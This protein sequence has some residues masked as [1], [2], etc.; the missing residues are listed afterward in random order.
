[1]Q[2]AVRPADAGSHHQ[3][4]GV[5][6]RG[7]QRIGAVSE[8]QLHY[9]EIAAESGAQQRSRARFFQPERGHALMDL[10]VGLDP[11]VRVRAAVEQGLDHVEDA[12]GAGR[13]ERGGLR[14][15][16]FYGEIERRPAFGV[17]EVRIG[18]VVDQERAQCR[19]SRSGRRRGA[20]CCRRR[21]SD[22]RRRATATRTCTQSISPS[23]TAKSRA[24]KPPF[25]G[26]GVPPALAPA[27]VKARTRGRDVGSV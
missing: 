4:R 26:A 18:A 20:G 23:R 5:V 19:S 16:V 12:I 9:R 22:L 21:R 27:A 14:V 24:V 11:Q 1:M 7:D 3:R 8:E 25:G 10:G 15:A 13:G 17:G 6:E 2:H